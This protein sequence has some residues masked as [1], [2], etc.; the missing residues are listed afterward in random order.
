MVIHD[1]CAIRHEIPVHEA[2]RALVR[3][4][5]LPVEEMPHHGAKTLCCGEGGAAGLWPRNWPGSGAKSGMAETEDRE[6]GDL[7][8][9]L[10]QFVWEN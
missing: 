2:V 3:N 6:T 9:R 7:L 8:R 10:F 5:G 1:P 4:Q